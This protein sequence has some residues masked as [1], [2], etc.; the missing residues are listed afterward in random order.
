MAAAG[1]WTASPEK[2]E[3]ALALLPASISGERRGLPAPAMM[4]C[5]GD[6]SPVSGLLFLKVLL[7]GILSAASIFSR[8]VKLFSEVMF[9]TG[10]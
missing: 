10:P 5:A 4:F 8:L 1:P 9:W 2:I 3:E 7:G 6:K